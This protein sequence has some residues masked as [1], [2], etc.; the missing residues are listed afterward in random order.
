MGSW[1]LQFPSETERQTLESHQCS[2]GRQIHPKIPSFR[3]ILKV[4]IVKMYASRLVVVGN[5]GVGKTSLL[6]SFADRV[7]P[8]EDLLRQ[9]FLQNSDS[10]VLVDEKLVSLQLVDTASKG[11]YDALRPLI[12]TF[13]EVDVLLVCFSLDSPASFENVS[14]KWI[15]EVTHYCPKTPILLVGTKLDLRDN[16]HQKDVKQLYITTAQGEEKAKEINAAGYFEVSALTDVGLR[17]LFDEV[18]R[19][20]I[21]HVKGDTQ[22]TDGTRKNCILM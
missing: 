16:L 7:F 21:Q 13:Q 22:T 8:S 6:Y 18:A 10:I 12:Y 17:N 15:P 19:V 1:E 11:G 9:G 3:T 5:S 4:E 20:A 14:A 2:L